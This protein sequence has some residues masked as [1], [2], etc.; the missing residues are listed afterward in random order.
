MPNWTSFIP[1]DQR[2][3]QLLSTSV[4]LS[5][6]GFAA[7]RYFQAFLFARLATQWAMVCVLVL[8]MEV[9]ISMAWGHF[10]HI[11]WWLY[12]GMYA[13]AFVIL[14][15]SWAY[16]VRRAGNIRV[17]AEGLAMRDAV[18]QLNHGYSQPIAELVD[19][20]EWKDLYTHGHV[21]R[22]ASYAVMIGKELG[23]S[24]TEL[25][26][27]ALGAQMHDVGKIGVP[28]RILKKAGPLTDEEF[29]TIKLHAARGYEI[30]QQ[31][32]ALQPASEAIFFHHER[33]DG[34][35]YPHGL[36]GEEI[37]LHARIVSV[38]DA[39]DAMTSGRV[40]QP[41]VNHELA[42]EEL[43]RCAGTHFDALCVDAFALVLKRLDDAGPAHV[44]R[45]E[46]VQ[47][48]A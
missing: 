20:I 29:E 37:P 15:V 45:P 4:T 14:F 25:R 22:V 41:A 21:R 44:L 43:R 8:L 35:G 27:L 16:E 10:W 18:A 9:Q 28:D 11:S 23:L 47:S 36:R 1:T 13:M 32:K 48:A 2:W 12:H 39:F 26:R 31:V 42:L 46:S 30:A 34:L 7:Y 38:A 6:L 40:Y 17:V 33:V 5:L 19:A 3:V 24:S